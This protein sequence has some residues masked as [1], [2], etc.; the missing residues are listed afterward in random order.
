M[1]KKVI[2]AI[3][4]DK[5]KTTEK[6]PGEQKRSNCVGIRAL[7]KVIGEKQ[8]IDEEECKAKA[9]EQQMQLDMQETFLRQLEAPQ[10]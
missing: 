7:E 9:Q 3:M 5:K 10:Q 8:Q 2:E 6:W 4:W 1:R